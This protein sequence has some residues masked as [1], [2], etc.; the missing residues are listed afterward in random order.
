[1]LLDGQGANECS[2]II[3]FAKLQPETDRLVRFSKEK[4]FTLD[5]WE[6]PPLQL[7][8]VNDFK[9]NKEPSV[10]DITQSLNCNTS[11]GTFSSAVLT[12]LSM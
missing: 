7:S 6:V 2:L 1:M 8:S 4:S 3:L 11:M 10:L 5:G 9:A 12:V